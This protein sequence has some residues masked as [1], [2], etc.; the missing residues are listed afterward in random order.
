[1]IGVVALT[2]SLLIVGVVAL[3][4]AAGNRRHETSNPR[5]GVVG[6]FADPIAGRYHRRWDT[7]VGVF[8]ALIAVTAAVL[9]DS[10]NTVAQV[11]GPGHER[12]SGSPIPSLAPKSSVQPTSSASTVF[13]GPEHSSQAAQ[14][15]LIEY[16]LATSR[17][18]ARDGGVLDKYFRFPV[19]WYSATIDD[20][21]NLRSHF[22]TERNPECVYE[23]PLVVQVDDV[24]GI[25]YVQSTV[26]WT[27]TRYVS[28]SGRSTV[29]YVLVD[30]G[31]TFKIVSV[32]EDPGAPCHRN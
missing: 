2:L 26:D 7:L 17:G 15:F 21:E 32:A 13:A 6:V 10:P 16:Y 19:R 4:D 30:S 25:L 24:R 8:I 12:S 31:S 27:N 9:T 23:A 3:L 28:R 29:Y 14:A 22:S 20:A 11:D 5:Y 1:M 18:G